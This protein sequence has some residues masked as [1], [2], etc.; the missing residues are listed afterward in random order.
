MGGDDQVFSRIVRCWWPM[1]VYGTFG[2][3]AGLWTCGALFVYRDVHGLEPVHMMPYLYLFASLSQ[4]LAGISMLVTNCRV[5]GY[6]QSPEGAAAVK[7]AIEM[8]TTS[9]QSSSRAIGAVR[10]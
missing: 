8:R 7:A 1:L 9:V 4:L 10:A 3:G 5:R 2:V 6:F